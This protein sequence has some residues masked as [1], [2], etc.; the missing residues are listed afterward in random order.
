MAETFKDRIEGYLGTLTTSTLDMD[1][2]LVEEA[3][4]LYDLAPYDMLAKEQIFEERTTF[5]LTPFSAEDKRI[6]SV[7]RYDG[8]YYRN[9][10]EVPFALFDERKDPYS[11]NYATERSPIYTLDSRTNAV[12]GE[13]TTGIAVFPLILGA[14]GKFR[15]LFVEYPT[16][17][18]SLTA[19][20]AADFLRKIADAL[21]FKGCSAELSTRIQADIANLAAAFYDVSGLIVPTLALS[22]PSAPLF[23]YSGP[24]AYTYTE[25]DASLDEVD[26]IIQSI[27]SDVIAL[28]I[29]ATSY[30]DF[31]T[32]MT[33]GDIEL[34]QSHLSKVQSDIRE[35]AEEAGAVI[36]KFTAEKQ[37]KY[38]NS[39][40]HAL[41]KTNEYL[42][43]LQDIA[44]RTDAVELQ[45]AVRTYEAQVAEYSSD[46]QRF[47]SEINRFAADIQRYGSQLQDKVSEANDKMQRKTLELQSLT[48]DRQYYEGLYAQELQKIGLVQANG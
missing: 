32:A 3:R 45:N 12:S 40:Q 8:T 14:S 37:A 38:Q 34:A 10:T 20:N 23:S 25:A 43:R 1:D 18:I 21:V 33:N 7:L 35:Y 2:V 28:P 47:S 31:N 17:L 4:K 26:T 15:I 48:A 29:L 39:I 9:C 11:I 44:S 30:A 22:A 42:K 6:I 41:G 46:L 36:N 27:A 24:S 16:T 19:A 13:R 5:S